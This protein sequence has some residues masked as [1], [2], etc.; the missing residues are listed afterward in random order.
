MEIADLLTTSRIACGFKANS[1]KRC[2][3]SLGQLLADGNSGMDPGDIFDRLVERERL[4]STGLG[5]GV[6]IPHGRYEG[7]G[8][9]VGAFMQL[10]VPADFDAID[11]Q[12]VDLLFALLVP[13][14]CTD[15]HLQVLSRLATL[16][17]NKALCAQL[18]TASDPQTIFRLL[19]QQPPETAIA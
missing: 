3:E 14:E 6:A 1:K 8:D 15:E 13:Q 12:P 7:N 11:G 2:L 4:G 9:T 17:H 5:N 16:F 10:E 18:R 19:V